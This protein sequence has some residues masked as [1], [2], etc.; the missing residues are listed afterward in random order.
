MTHFKKY[1]QLQKTQNLKDYDAFINSK[2][3]LNCVEFDESNFYEIKCT[4]SSFQK[5][6]ICHHIV[7]LAVRLNIL[8]FPIWADDTP[9]GTANKRGRKRKVGP[10]LTKD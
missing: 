9:I 5:D 8:E 3:M 2:S 4:C 7:L 10:A 6:N 1:I